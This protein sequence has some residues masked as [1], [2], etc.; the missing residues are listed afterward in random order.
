MATHSHATLNQIHQGLLPPVH[1]L[2]LLH[3]ENLRGCHLDISDM[4]TVSRA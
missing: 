2:V 1:Q 3:V 4:Q